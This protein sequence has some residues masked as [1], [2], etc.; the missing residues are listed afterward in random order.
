MPSILWENLDQPGADRAAIEPDAQGMRLAGTALFSVAGGPYD[1]RYT[2]IVDPG[3]RTLLV[4]AHV[5]GPGRERRLSLRA[6]GTGSWRA[7]ADDPLE[8][9]DGALDVDLSF[10]PATNTLPIR[11]LGLEVGE[12]AEIPVVLVTFPEEGIE[13]V[14]QRYERTGEYTYRYNDRYDLTVNEHGFVTDYPGGWRAAA[15]A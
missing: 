9:L 6:D 10:T 14:T 7:L 3:W 13:L 15:T 1:V 5:Q 12:S 8:D 2:I 4:G 11:R